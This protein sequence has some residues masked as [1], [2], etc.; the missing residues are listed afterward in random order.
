MARHPDKALSPV[1]INALKA[2][3]RFADGNGLYLVVDER[4]SKRWLLRT[5]VHGRRRDMGL[6]ST[7]LISLAE[8]REKAR[9]YRKIARDGGDPIAVKRKA[10]AIVPTFRHAVEQVHAEHSLA[11]RNNKHQAQWINTL[12]KSAFPI[13]GDH[14]IDQIETSDVLRV[15][16]P[17]WLTRPETARRIRQRLKTVFDWAKIKDYRHNGNPVEHIE[18]ALPRQPGK[19]GHFEAM[20]YDD[21]PDFVRMFRQCDATDNVKLGLEFLIITAC[22]TSEV[23]NSCWTE[24]DLDKA[25]WTIPAGRMKASREHRVPVSARAVEI[26]KAAKALNNGSKFVFPGRSEDETMSNMVFLMALRRMG[27]KA[28]VHGFRSAFRDWAAERTN[29]PREICEAALAHLVKDKTEA[30]YRRGDLLEKRQE[31]MAVWGTFVVSNPAEIVRLRAWSS[32]AQF[33]SRH[34]KSNRKRQCVGTTRT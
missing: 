29:F 1:R 4:G 16:S 22:R 21:V 14:R 9:H 34:S 7:R 13:I 18:S 27:L 5:V 24:I 6:G 33:G 25:V 2:K 31:L 19:R 20:P 17:I 10:Q 11:W 3:G 26:L 30:A 28:T 12:E 32:Q 8:A 23:L 15:L